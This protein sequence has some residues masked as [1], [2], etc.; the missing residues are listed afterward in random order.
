MVFSDLTHEF[1]KLSKKCGVKWNTIARNYYEDDGLPMTMFV[2]CV[3]CICFCSFVSCILY[4]N[5]FSK[6]STKEKISRAKSK[7]TGAMEAEVLVWIGSR[8]VENKWCTKNDLITHLQDEY[9]ITVSET[10]VFN[11][12]AHNTIFHVR[13]DWKAHKPRSS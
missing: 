7:L 2:I 6:R 5:L 9:G 12:I 10:W 13:K 1:K 8:A 4:S 3:L 11:F